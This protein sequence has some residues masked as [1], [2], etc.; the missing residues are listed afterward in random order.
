MNGYFVHKA[1]GQLCKVICEFEYVLY[2]EFFCLLILLIALFY[3][4]LD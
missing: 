1:H 2:I 3:K 4:G